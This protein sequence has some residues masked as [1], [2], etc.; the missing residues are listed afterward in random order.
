M[1]ALILFYGFAGLTVGGAVSVLLSKKLMNAALSLLACFFG[2][3]TMYVFLKADFLAVTQL[4]VYV[5]GIL[6]LLLFGVM[7]TGRLPEGEKTSRNRALGGALSVG[8]LAVFLPLI[9]Q[10]GLSEGLARDPER[11]A[12]TVKRLGTLLMTD[13]LIP[14]EVAGLLL[15]FALV[16]ATFVAGKKGTEED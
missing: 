14:F 13:Y 15:L 16:G 5:G 9:F 1:L 10:A 12:S 7:F 6:V 8:L 3:A 11:E 4:M 2:M